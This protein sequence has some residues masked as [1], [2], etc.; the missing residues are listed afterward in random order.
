[1]TD[2]LLNASA[3]RKVFLQTFGCQMNDYDSAR[4]LEQLRGQNFVPVD[5]PRQADLVLLNTCAI[6]E[7]AEHKVYSLLGSLGG[8]KRARPE[9]VIGVGGCVAQQRGA[10]IMA[11]AP[12]V[13]LVF[14][15]DHL[16]DVPALL[17]EVSR[18]A[19]P[20]RT[21][22][23]HRTQRVANFVPDLGA[24]AAAPQGAHAAAADE[25]KAGLAITKG[26]NNFCT[27]CVVPHT[28]GREVSREPD[29]I[30]AEARSLARR[31]VKEITLLGQNVNSYKAGGVHFVEL[32]R[33]LNDV[34]GLERI[35]YTSPHPKD[36]RES[37]A[38]AHA[39]LPKLCEHVHLPVQSGSDRILAAMR[40][41]HGIAAYL[42]KM[43][44]IRA[45]VP[46]VALST[47]LIV[48]FPGEDED[49]FEATL[50]LMRRVRYD[51]VYAF[52]FSPRSDTPAATLPGQV[53]ERVRA[54][55][56]E[57]LLALHDAIVR[58]RNAALVGTRQ[59]LLIEG[60]H[61]RGG[62]MRGRT[63]GNKPALLPDSPREPG[64]LVPVEIVA[65][66]KYSLVA[67]DVSRES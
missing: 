32:L 49:D 43:A 10:E 37:L 6:R 46:G 26:C 57:R 4:L 35:R 13:D 38:R 50:E 62:A 42:D 39:E 20:V 21:A 65:A 58:E 51:Q 52:K 14:G 24:P 48:G 47:D 33:R 22:W 55:R 36:F 41:N 66:R 9:L 31:G 11:R 40:R 15:P 2:G 23:R 25:V 19:R 8:L 16:F 17:D 12:A 59:E 44:M 67:R 54:D 45:H 28:R 3:P 5:S 60:P 30:L 63:R 29:N 18:G 7:K 53:P 56:L 1:M 64:E 61:P 27:F 34:P